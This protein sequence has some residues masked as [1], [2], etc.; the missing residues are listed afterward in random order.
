MIRIII[1]NQLQEKINFFK[2]IKSFPAVEIALLIIVVLFKVINQNYLFIYFFDEYLCI[3]LYLLFITIYNFIF[4][5]I[6]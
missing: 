3:L 4:L 2:Q 5:N 6:D 1:N